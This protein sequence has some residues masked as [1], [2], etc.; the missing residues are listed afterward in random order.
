MRAVEPEMFGW[1]KSYV[2]DGIDDLYPEL[3]EEVM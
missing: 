2:H 3:E 1:V